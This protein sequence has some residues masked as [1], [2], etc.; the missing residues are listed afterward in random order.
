MLV[1]KCGNTWR[2]FATISMICAQTIAA[3]GRITIPIATP[4]LKRLLGS[5]LKAVP[6]ESSTGAF[7][8][9]EVNVLLASGLRSS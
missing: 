6:T 5:Y 4:A 7:A 1:W 2:I 8:T 3:F 9:Q